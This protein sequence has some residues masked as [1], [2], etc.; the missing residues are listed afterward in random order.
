[1]NATILHQMKH[2]KSATARR[3][4]NELIENAHD[5]VSYFNTALAAGYSDI[6]VTVSEKL[7]KDAEAHIVE[8]HISKRGELVTTVE[9]KNGKC[10]QYVGSLD[11][12][13]VAWNW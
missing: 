4:A 1:M 9:Y 11:Y 10:T 3:M 7:E 5:Y 6:R 2:S 8:Q 12:N 13:F